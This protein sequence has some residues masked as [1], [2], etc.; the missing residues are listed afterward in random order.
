MIDLTDLTAIH[1][2]LAELQTK[3]IISMSREEWLSHIREAE[4]LR[5]AADALQPPRKP[6]S[7][8]PRCGTYCEGDCEAIG[9]V[10]VD[11]PDS[12]PRHKSDDYEE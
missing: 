12:T 11:R 2:R 7:P 4:T 10:A 5:S 6:A 1:A 8:C 3:P 9:P